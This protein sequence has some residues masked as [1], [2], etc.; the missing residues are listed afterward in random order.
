[1]AKENEVTANKMAEENQVQQEMMKE[2]QQVTTK[3]PNEV[4]TCKRLAEYNH[5]K[6]EKLEAQKSVGPSGVSQYY[7]IGVI[8]V[9]GVIG[10]LGYLYQAKK[11]EVPP[12]QPQRDNPPKANKLEMD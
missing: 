8:L 6:R 4:K 9:V 7:G 2:P 3:D 11:G 1:M 10:V 5:K 12:Q